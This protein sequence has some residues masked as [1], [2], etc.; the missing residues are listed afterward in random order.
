MTPVFDETEHILFYVASRGHHAEVGGI[1][2][3]SMPSF[4]RRVEEEGVL[5]DNALLTR[6]GRMLMRRCSRC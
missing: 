5:I 4:S 2:P 1:T 6:D 3:G